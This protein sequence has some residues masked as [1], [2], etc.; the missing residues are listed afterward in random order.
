MEINKKELLAHK[1]RKTALSAII[2]VALCTG[3]TAFAQLMLKIG[4]AQLSFNLMALL[5][6]V[7]LMIGAGIYVFSSF[8][9]IAALKYGE[10]SILYPIFALS[11]IWVNILSAHYLGEALNVFKWAGI[12]AIL[13]G[14]WLIGWGGD[15]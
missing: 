8:I 13:L 12:S 2:V 5:T 6:N 7:P 10:L 14:V 3:L 15:K 4:S 9:F 11:Y 1:H